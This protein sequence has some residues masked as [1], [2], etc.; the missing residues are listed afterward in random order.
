M[1][2]GVGVGLVVVVVTEPSRQALTCC[3]SAEWA[4][5]LK[6]TGQRVC[7]EAMVLCWCCV[8]LLLWCGDDDG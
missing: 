7:T 6:Q 1:G 3:S 4:T 5:L 2:V 8:V